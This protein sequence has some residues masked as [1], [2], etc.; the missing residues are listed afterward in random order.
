MNKHC[1][2]ESSVAHGF[3]ITQTHKP[4]RSRSISIDCIDKASVFTDQVNNPF[5][6]APASS[7]V[8]SYGY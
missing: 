8:D 1:D 6:R 3:D 4:S 2:I 5:G 7:E